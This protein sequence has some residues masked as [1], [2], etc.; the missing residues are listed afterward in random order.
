MKPLTKRQVFWRI[1]LMPRLDKHIDAFLQG[2][3]WGLGIVLAISIYHWL[4]R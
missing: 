1:T 2:L 3:G 4:S